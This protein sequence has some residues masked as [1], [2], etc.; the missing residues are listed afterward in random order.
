MKKIIFL[1][2]AASIFTAGVVES[3]NLVDDPEAAINSILPK[4]WYILKVENDTY[5]CYRPPGK[6][7]AVFFA[8]SGTQYIKQQYQAVLYIM[9]IEYND[10]GEDPTGGEAQTWPA[11]L[12]ATTDKFKI[13]LWPD[14][15]TSPWKTM[16]EDILKVIIKPLKQQQK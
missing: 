4:D 1:L 13:Y 12:I 10:G 7:K 9:P 14:S 5:P 8:V 6:G 15:S 11:R 2:L 3:K 16:R